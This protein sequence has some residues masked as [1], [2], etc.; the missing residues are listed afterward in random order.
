[1]KLYYQNG[2][3]LHK[4]NSENY[5]ILTTFYYKHIYK[6]LL[7]DIYKKIKMDFYLNYF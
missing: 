2:C 5:Y 4:I 1:M 6:I 3:Y 7:F